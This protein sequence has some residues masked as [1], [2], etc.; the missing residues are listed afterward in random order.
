[1]PLSVGLSYLLSSNSALYKPAVMIFAGSA[2]GCLK[3]CKTCS[4]IEGSGLRL[5]ALNGLHDEAVG[6]SEVDVVDLSEKISE[7]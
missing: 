3:S 7:N 4:E 6:V 1:L 2:L 5:A